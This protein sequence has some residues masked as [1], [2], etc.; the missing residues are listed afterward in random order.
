[1]ALFFFLKII[2]D[3]KL[4]IKINKDMTFVAH[5]DLISMHKSNMKFAYNM[6][7]MKFL[8]FFHVSIPKK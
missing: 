7:K 1:M 5:H 4:L 3:T 2:L 6:F 8:L